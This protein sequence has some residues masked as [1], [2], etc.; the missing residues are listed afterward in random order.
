MFH[1]DFG[2]AVLVSALIF[3]LLLPQPA[4]TAHVRA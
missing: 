3:T 1:F 2:I 4:E